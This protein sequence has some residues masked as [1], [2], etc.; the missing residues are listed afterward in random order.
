MYMNC[1]SSEKLVSIM[2]SREKI[3]KRFLEEP[4]LI[5]RAIEQSSSS[6]V[7]TDTSG[8]IKY[9]NPKFTC[10]TGYTFEEAIGKN[11]RILKTGRTSIEEYKNLWETITSGKE[12]QG[13]FLNRKK[14]GEP[15]WDSASISPVKNSQGK[16]THFIALKKDI[17]AE[18]IVKEKIKE[19]MKETE[20]YLNIL[21]HDMKNYL[22]TSRGYL[23]ILLSSAPDESDLMKFAK[24]TKSG[25]LRATSLLDDI[26]IM[27]KL[28]LKISYDLKPVN[29]L[30]IIT[31]VE[32]TLFEMF[33]ERKIEI[34]K[35][36]GPK[37]YILADSLFK[38]LI[39]NLLLNSVK[40]DKHDKVVIE[41]EAKNT[42][43][44]CVITISDHAKGISMKKRERLFKRYSEFT[45]KGKGSG[46]GLF[47]VKTL[48][49]HYNGKLV[50]ESRDPRDYKLGTVF[51]ITL[52]V[53]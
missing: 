44:E 43:N 10:I 50:V 53:I 13:E 37:Y 52:P 36:L 21:T 3:I 19:S 4:E 41:I 7:I 9:V 28:R 29:L 45:S 34:I 16:I 42:E 23:D 38:Q 15:Y 12:W 35:K 18:K 20:L 30:S 25:V 51:K 22:F 31:K 5:F 47:I 8:I 17:T 2:I 48:V 39:L 32:T 1:I 27:M 46:L 6:I 11:P 49:D 40:N 14:N 33:P 26:S 24:R